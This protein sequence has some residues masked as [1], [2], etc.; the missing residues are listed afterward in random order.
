MTVSYNV[1]LTNEKEPDCNFRREYYCTLWWEQD[2]WDDKIIH[3]IHIHIHRHTRAHTR[4][5]LKITINGVAFIFITSSF[6][7][8]LRKLKKK[9]KTPGMTEGN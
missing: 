7:N 8:L 9:Q 6:F 2:N 4:H 3:R 5:F 1:T